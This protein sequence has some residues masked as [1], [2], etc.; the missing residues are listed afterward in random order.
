[1]AVQT[2]ARPTRNNGRKEIEDTFAVCDRC[3][4]S[5]LIPGGPVQSTPHV[6]KLCGYVGRAAHRATLRGQRRHTHSLVAR[7]LVQSRSCDRPESVPT[8]GICVP[9]VLLGK[10]LE[11]RLRGPIGC[12]LIRWCF[13]EQ[14]PPADIESAGQMTCGDCTCNTCPLAGGSSAAALTLCYKR[15]CAGSIR[16]STTSSRCVELS[17]DKV[18]RVPGGVLAHCAQRLVDAHALPSCS[19][20]CSEVWC[21]AADA[22]CA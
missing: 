12:Q 8:S 6:C 18:R 4:V 3:K 17:C 15:N 7:G 13:C 19:P 9:S 2:V 10:A 5:H 22:C 1:M 20:A 21:Q 16:C 11:C 14:N